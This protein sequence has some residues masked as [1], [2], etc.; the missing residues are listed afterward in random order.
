MYAALETSSPIVALTPLLNT[1]VT[2]HLAKDKNP[3]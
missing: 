3:P 2:N 1:V